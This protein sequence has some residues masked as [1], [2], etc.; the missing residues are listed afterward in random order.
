MLLDVKHI[1]SL[2]LPKTASKLDEVLERVHNEVKEEY[3]NCGHKF[4]KLKE[5]RAHVLK[6]LGDGHGQKEDEEE[7]DMKDKEKVKNASLTS[8]K[9]VHADM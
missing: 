4:Q 5:A 6:L 2:F 3:E 7:E 9:N 1:T 8:C